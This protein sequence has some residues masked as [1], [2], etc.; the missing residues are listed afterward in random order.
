MKSPG[1]VLAHRYLPDYLRG[2][3]GVR[4]LRRIAREPHG[5][6]PS[7]KVPQSLGQSRRDNPL[8]AIATL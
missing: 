8:A 5:S 2:E 1:K 7:Q 6:D 3:D 4:D